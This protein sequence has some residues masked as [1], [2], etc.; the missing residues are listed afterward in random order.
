[1]ASLTFRRPTAITFSWIRRGKPCNGVEKAVALQP[2]R[3]VLSAAVARFPGLRGNCKG[4]FSAY[5][6]LLSKTALSFLASGPAAGSLLHPKWT[7][8]HMLQKVL[9]KTFDLCPA[10]RDLC[11]PN[12]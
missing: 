11:F 12:F 7:Q 2:L 3:A 9:S 8:P 6:D 10:P 1:P 4:G 5:Q